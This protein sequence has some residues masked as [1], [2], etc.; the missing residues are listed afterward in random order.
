MNNYSEYY[1]YDNYPEGYGYP[2]DLRNNTNYDYNGFIYINP[3]T[4]F[5]GFSC[6]A[7]ILFVKL[8]ARCRRNQELLNIHESIYVNRNINTRSISSA[9]NTSIVVEIVET[10]DNSMNN[11]P[12]EITECC[13]CLEKLDDSKTIGKLKC[14]HIFHHKCIVKWLHNDQYGKVCPLCKLTV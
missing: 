1:Y 13:I 3:S 10:T 9:L 6:I 11:T 2:G 5:I 12:S 14:N 7:S 8:Y 4:L